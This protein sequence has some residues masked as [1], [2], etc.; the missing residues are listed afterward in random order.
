MKSKDQQLLEEAYSKV[1][2]AYDSA[3]TISPEDEKVLWAAY[4]KVKNGKITTRQ[5]EETCAK[6][7][8]KLMDARRQQKEEDEDYFNYW[9]KREEEGTNF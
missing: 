6:I 8:E 2:E 7:V 3:V 9:K 5:W 4:K 1:N